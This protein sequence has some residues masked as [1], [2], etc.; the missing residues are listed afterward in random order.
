MPS[1][2]LFSGCNAITYSNCYATVWTVGLDR[3]KTK[4]VKYDHGGNIT[5]SPKNTHCMSIC[6]QYVIYTNTFVTEVVSIIFCCFP[7]RENKSVG[8]DSILRYFLAVTFSFS[9][10][11]KERYLFLR[12]SNVT[13]GT[14]RCIYEMNRWKYEILWWRKRWLKWVWGKYTGQLWLCMQHSA[15]LLPA[16][17]VQHPLLIANNSG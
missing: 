6:Q 5:F 8:K 17:L 9:L 11:G 7:I 3:W 15:E 14:Y 13:C 1:Y 2:S 12:H 10:R 16:W 4:Y